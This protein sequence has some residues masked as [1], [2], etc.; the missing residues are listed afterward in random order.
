MD[1]AEAVVGA[2]CAVLTPVPDTVAIYKKKNKRRKKKKRG[3]SKYR[4]REGRIR[5][6]NQKR[7][8]LCSKMLPG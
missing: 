4:N 3:E 1:C 2:G 8:P 5:R 6:V 7:R